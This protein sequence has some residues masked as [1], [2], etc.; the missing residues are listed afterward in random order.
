MN[1]QRFKHLVVFAC[2]FMIGIY[3][4]SA[5]RYTQLQSEY[6]SYK[7]EQESKLREMNETL[8]QFAKIQKKVDFVNK[9]TECLAK[10]I[11]FEAGSEP[12]EG[13]IAVAQVTKNRVKSG[14]FANTYCGVI[15]E[16][17]KNKCQFSWTCD[18]R[19]DRINAPSL[20]RNALKIAQDFLL[21]NKKSAIIDKDV[22]FYHAN[23]V[24]PNWSNDLSPVTTIGSHVFY[25]YGN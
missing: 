9:E 21:K 13:K 6:Q 2:F 1:D 20:Y 14:K 4:H 22:Y 17:H 11:Y 3:C 24:Q 7:I 23:Y 8:E 18:G 5:Y 16:R 15:Y 12:V 25:K 10:N 19:S